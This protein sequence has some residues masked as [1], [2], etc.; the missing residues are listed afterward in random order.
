[1]EYQPCRGCGD[2]FQTSA[3]Q[4]G[5]CEYCEDK[6]LRQLIHDYKVFCDRP[7]VHVVHANGENFLG[8]WKQER[9]ALRARVVA[10]EEQ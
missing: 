5:F 2:L 1:M 8:T 4:S 3:L 7:F 6:E 9:D 10:L